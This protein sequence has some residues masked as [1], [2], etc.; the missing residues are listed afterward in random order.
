ML[1]ELEGLLADGVFF[2][3][4]LE[5]LAALLQVSEGGLPHEPKRHDASCDA[6]LDAWAVEL[7]GIF[8]RVFGQ[9]LGDRVGEIIT[10]GVDFLAESLNLLEFFAAKVVDVFV[11]GQMNPCVD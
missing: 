1:R 11:E 8:L 9:D 3:V 10:A 4:D 7:F 2:H 6:N 5:T